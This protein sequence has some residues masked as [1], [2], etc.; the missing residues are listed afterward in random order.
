[1]KFKKVAEWRSKKIEKLRKGSRKILPFLDLG[2]RAHTNLQE[3]LMLPLLQIITEDDAI[4]LE[5]LPSK[6]TRR[7]PDKPATGS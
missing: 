1:M 2:V 6:L 7:K 4:T 5:E 3:D